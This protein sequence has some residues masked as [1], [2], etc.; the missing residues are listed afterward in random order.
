MNDVTM[1]SDSAKIRK[2][3]VQFVLGALIG[4]GSA[5]L[6][7]F[8][9]RGM[10]DDMGAS[11]IVLAGVGFIYIL[12]G[13]MVGFGA[14]MPSAGAKLLNVEDAEE[15]RDQRGMLSL[16]LVVMLAIGGSLMV[17]ALAQAPGR[18]GGVIDPV[19]AFGLLVAAIA[20]TSLLGW[21]ADARYDE[22]DK[23]L[24]IEGTAYGFGFS[25]LVLV[26][27]G[28][29]AHLGLGVR[30]LPIDMISTLAAMFLFGIFWAVG[31][32]GMMVR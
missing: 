12:I 1:K 31:R 29:A 15:L 9:G 5:A 6:L 23:Q 2:I 32:R 27:W 14:M 3:G 8:A 24:S 18:P 20:G 7:L 11:R 10:L 16:S 17:I 26:P 21:L 28:A 22:L 19:W 25:L 13:A 4:G 30:L